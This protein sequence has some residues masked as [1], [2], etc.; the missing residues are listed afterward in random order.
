[1]NE[2]LKVVAE[3]TEKLRFYEEKEAQKE[4]GDHQDQLKQK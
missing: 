4:T 1:M 2:Q 3:L